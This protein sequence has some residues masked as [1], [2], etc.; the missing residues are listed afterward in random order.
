[1]PRF[2]LTAFLFLNMLAVVIKMT[3]RHAF[4]VKY[5]WVTKWFNV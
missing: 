3:L 2:F 5:I 4:N 1:M